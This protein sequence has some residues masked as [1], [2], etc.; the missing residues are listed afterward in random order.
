[1]KNKLLIP[2]LILVAA[3]INTGIYSIHSQSPISIER[4]IYGTEYIDKIKL[5]EN[6][7]ILKYNCW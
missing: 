3:F 5:S 2:F 4:A 6:R 7:K 1:M